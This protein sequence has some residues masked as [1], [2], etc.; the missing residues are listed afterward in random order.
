M[1]G[2]GKGVFS[3]SHEHRPTRDGG[4]NDGSLHEKISMRNGQ[5][6]EE[7]ARSVKKPADPLNFQKRE[8]RGRG[9]ELGDIR[10]NADNPF[11]EQ[12]HRK[13]GMNSTGQQSLKPMSR[14]GYARIPEV[15]FGRPGAHRD[16]EEDRTSHNRALGEKRGKQTEIATKQ[17]NHMGGASSPKR[18]PDTLGWAKHQT[19]GGF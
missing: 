10:Q 17:L 1:V 3:G 4:Q 12:S 5:T 18:D 9:Q 15:S 19:G 6:G 14:L 8:I 13:G 2:A 16:P 7:D 11:T